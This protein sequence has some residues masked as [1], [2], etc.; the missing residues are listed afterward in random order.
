LL[1]RDRWLGI[2]YAGTLSLPC[3]MRFTLSGT[4][5]WTWDNDLL[6]F[7]VITQSSWRVYTANAN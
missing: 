3:C 2:V 5:E 1:G 7:V 6:C 4:C